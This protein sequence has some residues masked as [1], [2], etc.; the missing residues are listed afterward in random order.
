LAQAEREAAAGES[1]RR[2]S[3]WLDEFWVRRLQSLL[4]VIPIGAFL[5]FHLY[6]N[7]LATQGAAEYNNL[8]NTLEHVPLLIFI[9]IFVLYLPILA[10]AAIGFWIVFTPEL[11]VRRYPYGR[12]IHFYLQ[13]LTGVIA[14][15]F[16]TY[17]IV[18]LRLIPGL[19]DTHVTFALV[20]SQ[21]RQTWILILYLIGATGTIY[22]FANG[23]WSFAIHWG[24][25]VGQRAQRT[26]A[27]VSAGVF[28]V[29]TLVLV[30]I[31]LAFA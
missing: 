18:T 24:I 12:N 16:L 6:V 3:P 10:H 28:V 11:N 29:L 1:A 23:L 30:R 31:I 17:H 25:T 7:Y 26:M 14:F 5:I 15:I 8:I 4:G 2:T 27:Y 21:L 13:R 19:N 22:H 9:E 20:Q